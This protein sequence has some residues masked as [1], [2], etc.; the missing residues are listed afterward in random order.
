MI[1]NVLVV[2]MSVLAIGAFVWCFYMENGR[3]SS[4]NKDAKQASPATVHN[5]EK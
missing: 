1:S 2:I 4:D 5:E 3:D